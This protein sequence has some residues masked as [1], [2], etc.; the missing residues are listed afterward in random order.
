MEPIILIIVALV[1]L[2]IVTLPVKMAGAA[3]GAKRTGMFWCLFAIIGSS[4]LHAIGVTVFCIGTIIAFLLSSLAFSIFMGTGFLGG[5]GIHILSIIFTAIFI[6]LVT[7][8]FGVSLV[9]L[10]PFLSDLSIPPIGF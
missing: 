8:V 3:M 2:F 10:L 7:V 1:G 4:I 9:E 6:V 5:I